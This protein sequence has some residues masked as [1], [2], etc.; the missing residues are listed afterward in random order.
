MDA[1]ASTFD[2]SAEV[3][4]HRGIEST[5]E[6]TH[7]HSFMSFFSHGSATQNLL[8]IIV[9]SENYEVKQSRY[10]LPV[11]NNANVILTLPKNFVLGEVVNHPPDN[12]FS[13][14]LQI[15]PLGNCIYG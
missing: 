4:L 5:R 15:M 7:Y 12:T 1:A 11:K 10:L 13:T 3:F 2:A 8:D 9:P 14:G 6:V